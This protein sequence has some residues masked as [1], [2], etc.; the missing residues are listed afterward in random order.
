MKALADSKATVM[1]SLPIPELRAEFQDLVYKDTSLVTDFDTARMNGLEA[2][3]M[4]GSSTDYYQL[5]NEYVLD[6]FENMRLPTNVTLVDPTDFLCDDINCWAVVNG[7]PYYTDDNHLSYQ[8][9]L[10]VAEGF[11]TAKS[12]ISPRHLSGPN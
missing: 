2:L 8:G 7:L 4:L 12:P 5:R 10:R 9:A 6:K 3:N 11:V 1:I